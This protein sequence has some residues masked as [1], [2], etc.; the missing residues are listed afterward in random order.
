MNLPLGKRR[1][2]RAAEWVDNVGSGSQRPPLIQ[3]GVKGK[4]DV[5]A[6]L[7]QDICGTCYESTLPSKNDTGRGSLRKRVTHNQ[8]VSSLPASGN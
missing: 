6:Q 1:P 8:C 3:A 4:S 7:R 5:V 2:W